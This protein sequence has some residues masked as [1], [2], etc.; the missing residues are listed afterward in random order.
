MTLLYKTRGNANPRGKPRVYFT[1]HQDDFDRAFDR[2]CKDILRTVDC[3]IYYTPNMD[4]EI[5]QEDKEV[6]LDR[7]GLFVIPVS[8]R[9][10]STQNRTMD[11][12]LPFAVCNNIPVLP[13]MLE[14]GLVPY[15][16]AANKFGKLQYLSIYGRDQTEISYEDKLK[17]FLKS[18]LI[19]DKTAQRIRAAFDAY[20]FLSYRKK[21]RRYANELMRLIHS[22][23]LCMNVA[24]WYDEFLTPG[25]DFSDAIKE[26]LGKS[27]LFT[28]LVTPNLI[29]EKNYI[30]TTEYP[31]A[32]EAGKAV[33]PAEM[34]DTDHGE[35]T[36]Q[37]VGIP[38]CVDPRDETALRTRIME[39]IRQLALRKND[40]DPKHNFLIGLAYLDGIDVEV[41]RRRALSLIISAAEAYLPEAMEKLAWM[42]HNGV[43]VPLDYHKELEWR[44]M[45]AADSLH[46]FGA[47]HPDTLVSLDN[48][49]NAY[50]E[51][52]NHKEQLRWNKIVYTLRCKTFGKEHPDTLTTLAN[53]AST[54]GELGNYE[55]QHVLNKLA[56]AS[57]YKLLGVEHP[58]TLKLLSNL[59]VSYLRLGDTQKA[60]DLMRDI[61][62][63]MSKTLGEEHPDTLMSLDNLAV[64]FLR[65]GD[66]QKALELA[67]KAYTLRCKVLGETHPDTLTS[68]NNLAAMY[69]EVGD[70]EKELVLG[71]KVYA[72]RRKILGE[73][74]PC[75]ITSLN[76]LALTYGALS[77]DNKMLQLEKKV[78]DLSCKAL[79]EEH[80]NTLSAMNNLSVTY[81]RLGT[82]NTALE[83]QLKAYELSCKVLGE[84]HPD[85]IETL[86]TLALTYSKLCDYEKASELGEK[87]YAL[88]CMILGEEHPSTLVA[89]S[90]LA[91]INNSSGNH[92]K[93]IELFEKAYN[94]R[95]K[96]F[97][98]KHPVT[99]ESFQRLAAAREEYGYTENC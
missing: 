74:H 52:G 11:T 39:A 70:H 92:E 18:V 78:Y 79:G 47:D 38:E 46:T 10:L 26:A 24:I 49:A 41:D 16:S 23:P 25:E 30:Q 84:K 37:Y 89:L 21:D 98:E 9:L 44:E 91:E 59:T 75:T 27:D 20:I 76:N 15:Y 58:K 67:R 81:C 40:T 4:E 61:Y 31:A 35:L 94:L 97:G 63:I 65:S 62:D 55:A 72:L 53:L 36:R 73:N 96:V 8:F 71:K 95:R 7:M 87:A 2:I 17:L 19:S 45:L 50:G 82:F 66:R 42:Y 85:T 22:D 60:L 32:L 80:P 56:F 34:V 90:N 6:V 33:L 51:I 14:P 43:G 12:D 93:S 86:D 68:L 5:P 28:L 64:T 99:V 54:Y 13:I 77:D 57:T 88:S 29:N 48:L 69:G 83:L 1:C 3:A